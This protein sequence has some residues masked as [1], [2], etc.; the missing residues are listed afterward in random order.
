MPATSLMMRRAQTIEE[1]VRQPRP[2]RRHEVDGLDR[3]Q[4]DHV[5]V[6]AAVAHDADRAH[7]QEH[8]EG[9]AD[10]VVQ[11]VRAQ[12]LDEDRVGLAQ[13]VGVLPA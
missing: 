12:L 1:L 2:A 4:R 11:P 5:V 10:L 13:Q 6:A 8:G 7:R 9:L 3:A